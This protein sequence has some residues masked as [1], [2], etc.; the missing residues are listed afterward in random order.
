MNMIPRKTSLMLSL[1]LVF[2]LPINASAEEVAAPAASA[3]QPAAQPMASMQD[4]MRERRRE[5]DPSKC[6]TMP[7]MA[8]GQDAPCPMSGM[9]HGRDGMHGENC[10][11]GG[12]MQ[13]QHKDCQMHGS[14][15]DKRVEMLEKRVDM[16]QMMIEMMMRQSG[17]KN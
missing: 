8:A 2:F 3:E 16:M 4:L 12:G 15:D 6:Q 14:K 9:G 11:T 13:G 17:G 5:Q 7:G 10:K 1:A